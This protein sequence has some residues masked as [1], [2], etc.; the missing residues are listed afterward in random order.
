M[1]ETN[2]APQKTFHEQFAEKIIE[3]LEAG[4]APWQ[5]PWTPAENLAPRNPVSG[6]VYKGVNRLN[7]ALA[8]Y[9]DPCWMTLRQADD[10]GYR[11][12]KGS[13]ATT[14]LRRQEKSGRKRALILNRSSP[15]SWKTWALI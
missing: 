7:L 11:I 6:V 1:S 14:L 9:D 12:K 15:A 5:R 3:M 8:G 13:H 10:A 4:T 2:A